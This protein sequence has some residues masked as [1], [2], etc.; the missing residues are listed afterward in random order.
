MW[1]LGFTSPLT[2]FAL[3]TSSR[4][5]AVVTRDAG[6]NRPEA[7]WLNVQEAMKSAGHW[8]GRNDGLCG[9]SAK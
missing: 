5:A 6:G 2:R 1:P 4:D 8:P 9:W 7:A 3:T